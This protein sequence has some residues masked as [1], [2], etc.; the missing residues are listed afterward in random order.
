MNKLFRVLILQV[1][2]ILVLCATTFAGAGM[3]INEEDEAPDFKLKE[4]SS[5][6]EISLSDYKG[7][8]I[9]LIQFWATWCALCK[10]QIPFL[11]NHYN[12]NK[13]L[14]DF[15]ILAI[16]LPSGESDNKKVKEL[17]DKYKIPYPVLIDEG[18]KVATDKYELSG[19]IPVIAIIDKEGLVY[20]QHVGELTTTEDPIPF[21]LDELRGLVEE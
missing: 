6:K 10:R 19:L 8:K 14:D 9:V 18:N 3:R 5:G 15:E 2:F 4:F 1:F 7:K 13:K 11:V 17:I 16:L 21:V 12:A 20:F